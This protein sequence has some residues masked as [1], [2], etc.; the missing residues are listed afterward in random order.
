MALAPPD[1]VGEGGDRQVGIEI[2]CHPRQQRSELRRGA[3]AGRE[4]RAVLGLTARA[5]DRQHDPTRYLV[6]QR[7]AQVFGHHRE[8]EVD[9]GGH[10]R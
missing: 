10:P 6:G 5:P 4:L 1:A 2:G 9:A 7:V 3:A 8:R